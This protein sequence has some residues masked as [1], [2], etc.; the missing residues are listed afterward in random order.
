[1][2]AWRMWEHLFL[3]AVEIAHAP[4]KI[5]DSN[6]RDYIAF[7]ECP[8][9]IRLLWSGRPCVFVSGHHG[10]FE[11]AGYT[12]GVFGFPTFAVAR[13]LDNPFLDRYVN[14]FRSSRGQFLLPK[15]GSA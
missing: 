13:P 11:L 1:A 12:M 10:N 9:M 14:E 2:L 5:H 8:E 6:W 3:M 7:R 4:R 15:N